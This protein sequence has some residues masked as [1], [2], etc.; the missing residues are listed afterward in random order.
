MKVVIRGY[1]GLIIDATKSIL[2]DPEWDV[3]TLFVVQVIAMISMV[4]G[5]YIGF[6]LYSILFGAMIIINN[7]AIVDRY[8]YKTLVSPEV[9]KIYT[10]NPKVYKVA[11]ELYGGVDDFVVT[12]VN[13]L[14]SLGDSNDKK[15]LLDILEIEPFFFYKFFAVRYKNKLDII[16]YKGVSVIVKN[17]AK[18]EK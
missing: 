6:W 12:S 18:Y 9:T 14:L 8:I 15:V 7:H 3:K 13:G 17:E 11:L 16:P 1:P 2:K 10:T 4:Y 5:V